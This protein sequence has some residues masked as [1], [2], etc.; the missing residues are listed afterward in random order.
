MSRQP[1]QLPLPGFDQKHS[2]GKALEHEP[3]E[4]A[5]TADEPNRGVRGETD[6]PRVGPDAEPGVAGFMKRA[7]A[8]ARKAA[9]DVGER[10]L[11]G[12]EHVAERAAAETVPEGVLFDTARAMG[13]YRRSK[14]SP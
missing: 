13:R 11:S 3:A 9:R 4:T 2:V 7:R 12:V 14:I 10:A 5:D 8:T 1:V 6:E